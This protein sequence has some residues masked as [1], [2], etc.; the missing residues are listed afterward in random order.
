[1]CDAFHV[2]AHPFSRVKGEYAGASSIGER[3]STSYK[4]IYGN[5]AL[6]LSNHSPC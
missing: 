2:F 3:T 4:G 1:M 6:S 5:P